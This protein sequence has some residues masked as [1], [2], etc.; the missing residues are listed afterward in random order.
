MN[1]SLRPMGPM[2]WIGPIGLIGLM[3]VWAALL[4]VPL[5]MFAKHEGE[6]VAHPT[7]K[8]VFPLVQC[9]NK[10][11]AVKPCGV[12]YITNPCSICDLF[13]LAKRALDAIWWVLAVPIAAIMFIYAGSLMLIASIGAGGAGA[14][15]RGKKVLWNVLIGILIAFFGWLIVDTVIKFLA[16]QSIGV[17]VPAVLF[18]S[19]SIP[20]DEGIQESIWGPW[21]EI[22][23][24]R[25]T[26]APPACPT[27]TGAGP[28]STVT[29]PEKPSELPSQPPTSP[30]P[31]LDDTTARS[32]LTSGENGLKI[33]STGRCS[34]QTDSSC[35][36]LQGLPEVAVNELLS[37]QAQL[38]TDCPTCSLVITGGTEI[39]HTTH[40]S[41]KAVVDLSS[42]D[43]RING[44]IKNK[45]GVQNPAVN[46]W[47]KGADNHYYFYEGDHWHACLTASCAP[48]S[49]V[50]DQKRGL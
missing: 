19:Q 46:T 4:A 21:N 9:G 3:V 18:E 14:Y 17:P 7:E 11:E 13:E 16:G 37:M 22:R 2:R 10:T 47:Y 28:S 30:T 43:E 1:D 36:S 40:G 35:T 41:G 12:Q 15:E 6:G 48:H 31:H 44:F 25:P 32:R 26:V 8:Q 33:V 42:K 5:V 49:V 23:C 34:S 39:G 38:K 27:A 20:D 50:N 29:P 45:I 24:T